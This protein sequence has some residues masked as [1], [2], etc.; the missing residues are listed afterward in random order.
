[1]PEQ[2]NHGYSEAEPTK[3][4]DWEWHQGLRLLVVYLGVVAPEGHGPI[5]PRDRKWINAKMEKNKLVV[6]LDQHGKKY[7]VCELVLHDLATIV[8][9]S[10]SNGDLLVELS[11]SKSQLWPCLL[12]LPMNADEKN[13]LLDDDALAVLHRKEMKD[14][15]D[16]TILTEEKRR[17]SRRDG[18]WP[19]EAKQLKDTLR[20]VSEDITQQRLPIKTTMGGMLDMLRAALRMDR[21]GLGFM[22]EAEEEQFR[23]DEKTLSGEELLEKS[24]ELHFLFE[25]REEEIR[26]LRLA[27]I[28]HYHPESTRRLHEIYS[29]TNRFVKAEY[30]VLRLALYCN[31]IWA[32]CTVADY[33]YAAISPFPRYIALAVYFYQRAAE[34][35][36]TEAMISLATIFMKEKVS[37]LLGKPKDDQPLA[38]KWIQ[39]AERRGSPSAYLY[40]VRLYLAGT[41]GHEKSHEHVKMYMRLLEKANR[42]LLPYELEATILKMPD[43]SATVKEQDTCCCVCS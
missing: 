8:D 16:E 21:L 33:I 38:V 25:R 19:P 10:F 14:E 27:A 39:A 9:Y 2:L 26:Y 15:T 6:E 36:C 42:E 37:A 22:E 3:Q 1:M 35:G 30:F 23:D 4:H 24:K 34:S 41:F 29:R 17:L 32:N 18:R 13:F 7:T 31:D 5:G 12:H 43:T 28:H 40:R 11:K 20:S